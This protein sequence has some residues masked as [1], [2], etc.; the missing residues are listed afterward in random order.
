MTND[1]SEFSHDD[2]NPIRPYVYHLEYNDDADKYDY[3]PIKIPEEKIEAS[4]FSLPRGVNPTVDNLSNITFP[5]SLLDKI[6]VQSNANS[7]C[8]LYCLCTYKS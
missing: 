3:I 5:Y 6:L 2:Y 1:N 4:Q 7:V 8:L